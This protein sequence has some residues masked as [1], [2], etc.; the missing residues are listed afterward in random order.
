M[1]EVVIGKNDHEQRLDR[2]LKKYFERANSS[3]IYKNIRKKNIV[4]NGKKQSPEYILMEGDVIKMFLS[5]ET[6]EKF[7]RKSK[8]LRSSDFPIVNFED[9]NI[10]IMEKPAGI[11]SH[12]TGEYEKNLVDM[13]VNYLIEKGDFVPRI[14]KAFRPSICN[15]LDRN[16]SGLVI[17]AKNYTALKEINEA[18][19]NGG[20]K[21]FYTTIVKGKTPKHFTQE[22]FLYKDD[23]K[24]QVWV[25]KEEDEN[26]KYI[27]TEFTTLYSNGEYSI[28]E[29]DLITG[30]THQIRSGL[31]S[32]NHPIIG[33]RKYG[34]SKV[35]DFFRKKFNLN[36]QF[37]HAGRL[38]FKEFS[39]ELSYLYGREFR[40]ELPS[41][42]K[43]I[44]DFL[45]E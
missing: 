27:K 39:G 36:N 43:E 9:E 21:K 44:S 19:R 30:R 34:N 40:M 26:S 33:D 42:F 6:I 8:N 25:K 28:L 17:G 22:A 3:F 23:N 4:V 10:I 38:L 5:D 20:V 11:L 41:N 37:L 14:S 35:N 12:S 16:T 18:I 15:R 7:I 45:K 2:F 24:N 32:M 1:K 29:V 13:M 31:Y